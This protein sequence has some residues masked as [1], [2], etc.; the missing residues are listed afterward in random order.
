MFKVGEVVTIREYDDMVN[1]YG[2]DRNGKLVVNG[3]IFASGMKAACGHSLVVK[4]VIPKTKFGTIYQFSD[5]I[6]NLRY[7]GNANGLYMFCE[8]MIESCAPM[9]LE[10]NDDMLF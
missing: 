9:T 5:D 3:L 2:L 6:I 4:H 7:S 10:M 1:E 8:D